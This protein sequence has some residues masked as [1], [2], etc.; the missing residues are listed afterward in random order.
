MTDQ[1]KRFAELAG[2]H[3]DD[4]II[5]KNC[6]TQGG[7]LIPRPC[8][9]EN[10][11]VCSHLPDFSDAREVLRVVMERED[12]IC[13]ADSYFLISTIDIGVATT[14]AIPTKYITTPGKL[15]DVAIEWM[16]GRKG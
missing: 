2:W 10:G 14:Y 15:R 6:I 9:R 4:C 12:W 13:F 16:E 8:Y 11:N 3:P 7:N 5:F 1:N